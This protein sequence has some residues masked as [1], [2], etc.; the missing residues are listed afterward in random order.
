MNEP[1]R[2]KIVK[3]PGQA[4]YKTSVVERI[5][6]I[7][8]P[9]KKRGVAMILSVHALYFPFTKHSSLKKL[10]VPFFID[11]INTKISGVFFSVQNC[12]F[13]IIVKFF[14][15]IVVLY[16][17]LYKKNFLVHVE[18]NRRYFSLQRVFQFYKRCHI[19]SF[20]NWT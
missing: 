17:H 13:Q 9:L 1:D 2:D 10:S 8:W 11:V 3:V 15:L 4:C 5:F 18:L 6:V 14:L 19:K 12:C 16:L 20:I 7:W